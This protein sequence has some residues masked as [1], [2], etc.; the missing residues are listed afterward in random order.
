[1][2]ELLASLLEI[3]EHIVACTGWAEQNHIAADCQSVSQP[4]RLHQRIDNLDSRLSSLVSCRWFIEIA[5]SLR[6][7][8]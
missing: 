6:S 8:Q 1:L 7:S 2:A 3:L 4:N 5:S